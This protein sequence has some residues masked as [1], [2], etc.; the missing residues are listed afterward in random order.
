MFICC[1]GTGIFY[2]L[3][4]FINECRQ[5]AVRPITDRKGEVFIETRCR[6]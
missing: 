6:A 4:N 5:N 3:P 2:F 1:L